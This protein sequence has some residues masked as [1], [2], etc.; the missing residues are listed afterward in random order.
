MTHDIQKKQLD[1][2]AAFC[3]R[4]A[5]EM[6]TH[7]SSSGYATR[8][9]WMVSQPEGAWPGRNSPYTSSRNDLL[10]AGLVKASETDLTKIQRIQAKNDLCVV[11]LRAFCCGE[12]GKGNELEVEVNGENYQLDAVDLL[13]LI[14]LIPGE[15]LPQNFIRDNIQSVLHSANT[16]PLQDPKNY[17]SRHDGTADVFSLIEKIQPPMQGFFDEQQSHNAVKLISMLPPAYQSELKSVP[18]GYVHKQLFL[19]TIRKARHDNQL[20]KP[21]QDFLNSCEYNEALKMAIYTDPNIAARLL[22]FDTNTNNKILSKTEF[23]E[24]LVEGIFHDAEKASTAYNK[25]SNWIKNEPSVSSVHIFNELR[26][27]Y[28]VFTAQEMTSLSYVPNAFSAVA[29]PKNTAVIVKKGDQNLEIHANRVT[30]AGN[31][32]A[33]AA[34]QPIYT[35]HKDLANLA[36]FFRMVAQEPNSFVF[37]LRSTND[38]AAHGNFD[39]CPAV[40]GKLVIPSHVKGGSIEVTTLAVKDHPENETQEVTLQLAVDGQIRQLTVMQFREWPDHGAV[41]PDQLRNIHHA[42]SVQE[43]SGKSPIVH[44]RAGVGRTGTLL[45]YAKLYEELIEKGKGLVLMNSD[46]KVAKKELRKVVAKA[47]SEGRLERGPLFVQDISQ[48][49]LLVETLE[50]DLQNSKSLRFIKRDRNFNREILNLAI[51]RHSPK[52][53]VS[54]DVNVKH[55]NTTTV[56]LVPK[57]QPVVV[58]PGENVDLATLLPEASRVNLAGQTDVVMAREPK[59]QAERN[60][61]WN[62]LL[63]EGK[64]IVEIVSDTNKLAFA[65]KAAKEGSNILSEGVIKKLLNSESPGLKFGDHEIL[66]VQAIASDSNKSNRYS[67]TQTFRIQFQTKLPD[68][69]LSEPKTIDYQQVYTPFDGVKLTSKQLDEIVKTLYTKEDAPRWMVSMLGV[70]RPSAVWVAQSI[71]SEIAKG[72][73][74]T[75][76]QLTEKMNAWIEQGRRDRGP[77][78]IHSDEQYAQLLTFG[79]KQL[80]IA[81]ADGSGS[82]ASEKKRTRF[83][84]PRTNKLFNMVAQVKVTIGKRFQA[85]YDYQF[86]KKAA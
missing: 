45:T 67:Y 80:E 39:Y 79:L 30:L 61:H 75:E 15:D 51:Q 38:L 23:A 72:H 7:Q 36:S 12:V 82:D 40:G 22:G 25:V 65:K 76:A 35:S 52:P 14:S 49:K 8:S 56:D 32:K 53:T 4:P 41:T 63:T 18:A 74:K 31:K 59:N 1:D 20:P 17:M 43:R 42:F 21:L 29:C 44:C 46:G 78:F 54:H 66:G 77:L 58:E 62:A 55:A 68:G 24:V 5:S 33:I 85:M 9:R 19:D 47:V 64:S 86:K 26:K 71:R 48:F 2:I 3:R 13:N 34:M 37:D 81:M 28:G 6:M 70:G 60:Q 84:F 11:A 69:S 50:N 57:P 73:I 16:K 27:K 83:A 10:L